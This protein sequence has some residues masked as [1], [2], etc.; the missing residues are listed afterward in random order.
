MANISSTGEV[1][2][3]FIKVK[4]GEEKVMEVMR[5]SSDGDRIV[6]YTPGDGGKGDGVSL[7]QTPPPVPSRGA[8]AFYSYQ[9][10][11]QKYWKKYQYA[12]RFINLVKATTPKMTLYTSQAKC[13]LMENEGRDFEMCF[14]TGMKVTLISGVVKLIDTE[15]RTHSFSYPITMSTVPS[16]LSLCLSHLTSSYEHCTRVESLLSQV[17]TGSQPAYPVILGRKPLHLDQASNNSLEKENKAPV[18]MGQRMAD[19][20]LKHGVGDSMLSKVT[21]ASPHYQH[22]LPGQTPSLSDNTR[23]VTIPGVGVAIQLQDGNVRVNYLD[24]SCLVLRSQSNT[25]DFYHPS[26]G[27]AQSGTWV[28]YDG[29]NLPEVV[30][31]KLP[32]IPQILE[33]LRIG[34]VRP[35]SVR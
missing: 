33:H 5:I 24:R 20:M 34:Q 30:K 7:G 8:D 29:S 9:T 2:L 11:P 12:A 13:Y 28:V 35:A 6:L 27:G 16:S 14:Y 3:E 25:V 17:D 32:E 10:L 19:T 4:R 1:C 15:G 21:T 18:D 23:K 26:P 31:N 22:S